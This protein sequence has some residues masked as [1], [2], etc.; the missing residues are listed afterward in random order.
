LSFSE[1]PL[2]RTDVAAADE[3]LLTST[4]NCLLPVTRFDGLPIGGGRP[5]PLFGRLLA[6]W[7][8]DVGLDIAAQ[9]RAFAGPPPGGAQA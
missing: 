5:G 6:A 2:T 9:A 3:I 1:T 4:P 8:R 7:S